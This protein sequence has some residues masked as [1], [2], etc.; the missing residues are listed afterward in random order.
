MRKGPERIHTGDK[1]FTKACEVANVVPTV[2]QWNKW[3]QGTGIARKV[4]L[5]QAEP[6]PSSHPAYK[7]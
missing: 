1:L 3:C 7:R 2:R 5:G 6:L 4:A